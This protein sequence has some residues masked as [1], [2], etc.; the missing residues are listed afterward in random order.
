MSFP[1]DLKNID[2][3]DFYA[4]YTKIKKSLGWM[5]KVDAREGLEKTLAYYQQNLTQY[6]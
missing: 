6:L 5:P 4:D 2:I 3:G 1:P